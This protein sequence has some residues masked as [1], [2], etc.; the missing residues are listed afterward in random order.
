MAILVGLKARAVSHMQSAPRPAEYRFQIGPRVLVGPK[1][2]IATW[3]QAIVAGMT[4]SRNLV[5]SPTWILYHQYE[6][7][8]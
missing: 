3:M 2:S 4:H 1:I 8:W 5:H 6:K 7:Y